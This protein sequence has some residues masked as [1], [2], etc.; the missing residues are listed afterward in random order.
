M[1]ALTLTP[2]T[3]G[4][5]TD[6]VILVITIILVISSMI[7]NWRASKVGPMPEKRVRLF[8]AVIAFCYLLGYSWLLFLNPDPGDWSSVMR[9][10]SL[11][12]W[13]FVWNVPPYLHVR[14]WHEMETAV[15]RRIEED[16]DL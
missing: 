16:S 14:R 3:M 8:I 1:L 10:F 7:F 13:V 6:D 4:N 15:K 12:A 11:L 5:V 9:G 2:F